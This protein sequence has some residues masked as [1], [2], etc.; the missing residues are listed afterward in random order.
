MYLTALFVLS[1]MGQENDPRRD[2]RYHHPARSDQEDET[3]PSVLLDPPVR[4]G[5]AP[6]L[7]C[8]VNHPFM[9]PTV[10]YAV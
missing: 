4:A 1:P 8:H 3:G 6:T 10:R 2:E 5:D 7:L 9:W